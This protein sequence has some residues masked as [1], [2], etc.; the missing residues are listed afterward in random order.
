MRRAL[1]SEAAAIRY[2]E[3]YDLRGLQRIKLQ[4]FMTEI[5][6]REV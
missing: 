6:W 2:R 1:Y 5:I 3:Q 4:T